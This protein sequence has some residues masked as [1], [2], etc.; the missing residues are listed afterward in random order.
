MA[1]FSFSTI[2]AAEI[3]GY[4]VEE[5]LESLDIRNIYPNEKAYEVV[6]KV[7]RSAEYGGRGK[8]RSFEV[9]VLNK[10]GEQ[11]YPSV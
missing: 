4:R 3:F 11:I 6:E 10:S 8:L 2:W 9:D 1:I 5:A 7:I